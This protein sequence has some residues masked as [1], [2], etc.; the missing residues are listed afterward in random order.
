MNAIGFTRRE[1]IIGG[2]IGAA[3]LVLGCNSDDGEGAGG[4]A[5]VAV[6]FDY[7]YAG[8]PGSMEK[9]WRELQKRL[10]DADEGVT[11][12][13]LRFVDFSNMLARLQA[14][15]A[16]KKGATLETY[17]QGY[18][19]Y[20]FKTQGAITPI[21]EYVG[22]DE[23][24]DWILTRP[25]DGEHWNMPFLAESALVVANRENLEKARVELPERWASYEDMT[26]TFE[27]IKKAG[28]TPVMLGA[29][30]GFGIVT[31]MQAM[32]M[33]YSDGYGDLTEFQIGNKSV[34]DPGVSVW[35]DQ[36][37]Q[38][39]RDGYINEDASKIADQQAVDRFI[40]GEGAFQMLNPG[41]L[42][43]D[44][45]WTLVPYWKGPSPL[46]AEAAV[47]GSGIVMTSYGD[48]KEA[49]G[50][51]LRFMQA[52]PQL[53][54]F[55]EVTGE[56]PCNRSFD[57]A[58]LKGIHAQQ[59]E[60]FSQDDPAPWWPTENVDPA[61]VQIWIDLGPRIVGGDSP[62]T[63]RAAYAERIAANREKD[64]ATTEIME[65]YAETIPTA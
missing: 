37:A 15:H 6:T 44:D 26:A 38:F 20:L 65:K 64:A 41:K 62:E 28:I 36:L 2:G 7:E 51:L 10:A 47:A 40:K 31:W 29:S 46:S 39:Y 8:K 18:Y 35:C 61:H 32:T 49:A 53:D 55:N 57:S 17:Y 63:V 33:A 24:E 25:I 13:D 21:D 5:P 14:A 45:K 11:I 22:E 52:G 1:A 9:Y 30:D 48:N 19:T 27:Q 60:L 4:A 43:E 58:R 54:L 56:L 50:S 23:I 34:E 42:P 16:A 59:W 3:A 12:S